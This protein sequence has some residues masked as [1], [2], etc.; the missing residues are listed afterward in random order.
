MVRR[1]NEALQDRV[2]I[3]RQSKAL[4][5]LAY[6]LYSTFPFEDQDLLIIESLA[7]AYAAL[8]AQEA[9][10]SNSAFLPGIWEKP[11]PAD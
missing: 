3:V 9:A 6:N 5:E 7:K 10:L 2:H 1:K 8:V 11:N 4:V